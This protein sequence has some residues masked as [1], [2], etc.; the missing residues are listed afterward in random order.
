MR[1]AVLAPRRPS[2]TWAGVGIALL[3]VAVA[4]N[5][6]AEGSLLVHLAAQPVALVRAARH[7]A[8]PGGLRYGTALA[9]G[10]DGRIYVAERS[11]PR[12]RVLDAQGHELAV[13]DGRD[14]TPTLR[15]PTAL[16][17]LPDGRIAL[18]DVGDKGAALLTCPPDGRHCASVQI[19]ALAKPQGLAAR[20]AGG[21]LI[22]DT[23]NERV[24]V[25]AAHG[26]VTASWGRYGL[27]PGQFR[28]PWGV[29]E[30]PGGA[31]Y[32]ADFDDGL[33]EE[34]SPAGAF[35]REWD[36]DGPV[37]ALALGDGVLYAALPDGGGLEALRL[38]GGDFRRLSWAPR[39]PVTVRRPFGLAALPDGRLLVADQDGLDLYRMQT[40]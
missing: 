25:V 38:G 34:L 11:P 18:L 4:V 17:V 37:G 39:R 3:L 16:S 20:R 29:V 9:V 33:V 13:W 31:A 36:T 7:I 28:E 40:P 10:G 6:A 8:V 15:D 22:A 24:A 32:V 27:L 23:A 14:A 1:A 2:L 12:V 35:V 30:G 21:F 5:V 26:Q 19:A